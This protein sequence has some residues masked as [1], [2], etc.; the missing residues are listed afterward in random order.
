MLSL[1]RH[2]RTSRLV[3]HSLYAYSTKSND[4]DFVHQSFTEQIESNGDST[5]VFKDAWV[6]KLI[7]RSILSVR[8]RDATNLLQNVST[9]DMGTF[10]KEG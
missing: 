9:T 3:Q 2:I 8:G 1:A 7:N 6:T 5:D 10:K 4:N